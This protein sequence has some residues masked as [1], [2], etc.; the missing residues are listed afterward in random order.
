MIQYPVA[1]VA[2]YLIGAIPTGAL[3]ATVYRRVDLT[4]VGSRRT[5]ATNVLR[6]LG[7]GAAAVVFL[8]DFLKGTVVVLLASALA[9]GDAW[10]KAIAG[11]A[12]VF[13]HAFSPFLGFRGGRG[14]T[15]GLGG[16]LAIAPIVAGAGL[17][18]GAAAIAATRYVSLGSILG[19]SVAALLLVSWTLASGQPIAY[20]AFALV[21]GGF[22]LIA[23][24][25]N[26]DRLVHGKERKLG[27]RDGTVSRQ[28]FEP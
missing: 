11:A 8:G 25:D 27:Q 12:A 28:G 4:Q 5:G 16:L 10:V 22:I 3:V 6:T 13:G 18:T 2:G 21:V 7:P 1:L 23:H 19:T 17:L 9:G 20:V 26:I 14:V 24:H 15:T